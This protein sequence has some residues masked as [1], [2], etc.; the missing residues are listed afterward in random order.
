[1]RRVPGGPRLSIPILHLTQNLVQCRRGAPGT[2]GPHDP[3]HGQAAPGTWGGKAVG[4]RPKGL[5]ARATRRVQEAAEQSLGPAP[6]P[7]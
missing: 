1:M 3:R 7:G 2:A 4:A 6:V 5:H